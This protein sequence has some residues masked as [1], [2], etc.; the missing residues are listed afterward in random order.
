ML[1]AFIIQVFL[2]GKSLGIPSNNSPSRSGTYNLPSKQGYQDEKEKAFPVVNV[3]V[4]AL[5]GN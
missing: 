2:I 5:K 3:H 4:H 1:F